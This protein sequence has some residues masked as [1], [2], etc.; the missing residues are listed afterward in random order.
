MSATAHS[1]RQQRCLASSSRGARDNKS[2][3]I[4]DLAAFWLSFKFY[5]KLFY[6]GAVFGLTARYDWSDSGLP[7][8]AKNV[9]WAIFGSRWSPKNGFTAC[10]LA[11]GLHFESLA[12][13][14]PLG[15]MCIIKIGLFF[16]L[17]LTI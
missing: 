17:C 5:R 4:L 11:L 2:L 13:I 15:Y 16:G 3:L 8:L 6:N 10:L 7:D 12:T 1:G 9:N 14:G